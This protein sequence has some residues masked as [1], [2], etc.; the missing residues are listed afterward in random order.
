MSIKYKLERAFQAIIEGA[1]LDRPIQILTS[2]TSS[3]ETL[4]PRRVSIEALTGPQV[5]PKTRNLRMTV[6]IMVE[7]IVEPADDD[8]IDE[9]P[10]A[11]HRLNVDAMHT[12]LDG[13]DVGL[14]E[15]LT[16]QNEIV[17]IAGFTCFGVVPL[18]EVREPPNQQDRCFRD[19]WG[20]V[21]TVCESDNS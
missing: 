20:Y 4:G 16:A 1:D 13:A 9:D 18:G 10:V 3:S 14:A 19:V 21:C 11:N 5:T 17:D 8:P 15:L 2:Q 12:A 6:I 7:R